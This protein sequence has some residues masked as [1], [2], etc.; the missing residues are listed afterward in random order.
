MIRQILNWFH[1]SPKNRKP[2]V[3]GVHNAY[4]WDRASFL[5]R[6]GYKLSRFNEKPAGWFVEWDGKENVYR[7]GTIVSKT[8]RLYVINDH[9]ADYVSADWYV[10]PE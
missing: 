10:L 9:P 6:A 5:C 3:T 8:R 2:N 7:E 1:P 4:G